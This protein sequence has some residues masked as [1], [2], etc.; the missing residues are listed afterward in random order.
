MVLQ[1]LYNVLGI[2]LEIN[3]LTPMSVQ[4]R[5]FLDSINTILSRQ[6]MKIKLNINWGIIS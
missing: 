2:S 3:L 1:I 6:V 5:S 4:D